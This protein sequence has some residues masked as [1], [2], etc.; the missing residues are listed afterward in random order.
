MDI[1]ALTLKNLIVKT[2]AWGVDSTI[3]ST[4]IGKLVRGVRHTASTRI[5][6]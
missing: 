4:T 1:P 3:P 2:Q 5:C 6:Y